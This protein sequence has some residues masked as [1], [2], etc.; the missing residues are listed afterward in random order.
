[1]LLCVSQA[2]PAHDPQRLPPP[3][4]GT[5]LGRRAPG[6]LLVSGC[7]LPSECSRAPQTRPAQPPSPCAPDPLQTEVAVPS[8]SDETTLTHSQQHCSS[9]PS[10]HRACSVLPMGPDTRART[11]SRAHTHLAPAMTFTQGH[12]RPRARGLQNP[13]GHWIREGDLWSYRAEMARSRCPSALGAGTSHHRGHVLL[14]LNCG[15][16]RVHSD[17]G[18][19]D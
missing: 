13:Q 6:V 19:C 4:R 15:A 2:H 16:V 9:A 5:L 8:A 11:H 1:M 17:C 3:A 12:S 7:V 18:L 10:T 14:T